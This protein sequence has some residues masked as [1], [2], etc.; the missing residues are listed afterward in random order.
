MTD[1]YRHYLDAVHTCQ[2]QGAM[3][4]SLPQCLILSWVQ[5]GARDLWPSFAAFLYEIFTP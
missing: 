4:V 1:V 3:P 2:G 5:E